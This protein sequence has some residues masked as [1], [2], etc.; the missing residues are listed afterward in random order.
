MLRN[1]KTEEVEVIG[2]A[3]VELVSE[4]FTDGSVAYSVILV[5]DRSGAGVL[6][7]QYDEDAAIKAF[8]DLTQVLK[9]AAGVEEKEGRTA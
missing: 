2:T 5:A 4:R 1:L 6:L 7:E 3:R 9:N 8:R